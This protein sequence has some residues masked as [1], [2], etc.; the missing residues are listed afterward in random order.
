MCSTD[1]DFA[2]FEGLDRIDPLKRTSQSRRLITGHPSP[3]SDD[4]WRT[5]SMTFPKCLRRPKGSSFGDPHD[6]NLLVYA[7]VGSFRQHGAVREWLDEKINGTAPFGLP[8]PSLL[9]FARLVSNP[10]RPRK[11][12]APSG[13]PALTVP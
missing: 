10:H 2:G 5:A 13:Q 12:V 8:W 6:A 11:V 7:H 9:G 3:L 4:A 1:G